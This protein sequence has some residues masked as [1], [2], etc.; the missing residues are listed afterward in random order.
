MD[1]SATPCRPCVGGEAQGESLCPQRAPLVSRTEAMILVMFCGGD[2]KRCTHTN[3]ICR[4]IYIYE[5]VCI[6][7]YTYVKYVYII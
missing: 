6:Y 1:T 7:I 4:Y 3:Y 5:Y 2:T